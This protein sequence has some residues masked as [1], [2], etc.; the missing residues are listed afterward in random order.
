MSE[1][2]KAELSHNADE[3]EVSCEI[4]KMD[5]GD[6]DIWIRATTKLSIEES[7]IQIKSRIES[8]LERCI[9]SINVMPAIHCRRMAGDSDA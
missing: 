1:M 5:S 9:Y 4:A 2:V 8:L 6:V 3:I 7:A